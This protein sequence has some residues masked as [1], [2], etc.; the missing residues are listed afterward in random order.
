MGDVP[1][2]AAQR[3]QAQRAEYGQFVATGR[4]LVDGALAFTK[5]QAVPA[6]NVAKHGYEKAGLVRRVDR[7]SAHEEPAVVEP[8][9]I[10]PDDAT[11]EDGARAKKRS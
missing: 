2:P 5:G 1:E 7:A 11:D 3:R 4:I 9:V 10:E 8:V 6:S